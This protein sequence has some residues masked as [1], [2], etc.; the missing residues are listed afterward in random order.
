MTCHPDL[1]T[2]APTETFQRKIGGSK[3]TFCFFFSLVFNF[4]KLPLRTPMVSSKYQMP[5]LQVSKCFD[6]AMSVVKY[7]QQHFSFSV[8]PKQTYCLFV[9]I[10]PKHHSKLQLTWGLFIKSI[11]ISEMSNAQMRLRY[12]NFAVTNSKKGKLKFVCRDNH[13]VVI[14]PCECLQYDQCYYRPQYARG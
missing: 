8:I 12:N 3:S 10:F 14:V 1:Y 4:Q 11:K 6:C 2:L 9:K 7:M 5:A 13:D